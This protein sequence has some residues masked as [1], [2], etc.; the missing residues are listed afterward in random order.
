MKW[1]NAFFTGIASCVLAVAAAADTKPLIISEKMPYDG[2][3]QVPSAVRAE[4]KLETKLSEYVKSSARSNEIQIN[5]IPDNV[6]QRMGRVLDIRIT[7]VH[8]FGGGAH[9]GSKSV[10]VRGE[11]REEGKLVA[12]FTGRRS[13]GGGMWGG[14]KGTCSILDR[15]IKVLG[16]DI[17]TWLTQPA[18]DSRLGEN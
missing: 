12:S 18:M 15:C 17:G 1:K 14:F 16:K 10:A 6:A 8:G 9:T 5:V 3:A 2:G 7:H 11:L 4:C 13:S